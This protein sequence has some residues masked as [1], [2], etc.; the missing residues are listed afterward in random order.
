MNE[1]F[2]T[3][4]KIVKGNTWYI[5]FQCWHPL[6]QKLM[7]KKIYRG[8]QS[9]KTNKEKLAHGKKL[10]AEYEEKLRAG[11]NPW[12]KQE[13]IIYTDEIAYH[14][15]SKIQ[16]KRK[17]S[18]KNLRFYQS[19][20]LEWKKPEVKKKTYQSYTSKLRK[21]CLWTEKNGFG[22][23]DIS[24]INN[25]IMQKFFTYL[26]KDLN[27]DRLTIEKYEQNIRD[28]FRWLK[29][30]KKILE[31]PVFD[32]QK[33]KKKKDCAARPIPR[34]DLSLLLSYIQ[35]KDKQLFLACLFQYYCFIRPGEELQTLKIKDINF[36]SGQIRMNQID[37]KNG[38][39]EVVSMPDQLLD[40]CVNVYQ[41]PH[42]NPEYFVFGN[43]RTPGPDRYGQNTLRN[44]FNKYR[45][46]L[47]L[48]D[49]YKFYSMKHSGAGIL[50]E[51]GATM[52]EVMDQLRHKELNTTHHYIKR[53]FG[54]SSNHIKKK[55]P[56]P[57]SF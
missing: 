36:Y 45:K 24:C 13:T 2:A 21:L 55:F 26:D 10:C 31:N 44:R 51:S 48:P 33:P 35:D 49:I 25:T 18:V 32:I 7:P 56:N 42:F 37:A 40:L 16:G 19:S 28:F 27:L 52:V 9:L 6:K 1:K 39:V 4:P 5:Y 38:E 50:L 43:K 22:N 11:W 23:Y 41:L 29:K 54:N 20:Y 3:V 34:N 15:Q 14:N 8:F 12:E 53:H 17:R 57:L 30:E 47:G 46:E